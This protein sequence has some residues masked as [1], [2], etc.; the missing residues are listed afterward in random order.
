MLKY[1]SD[2]EFFK[3][4]YPATL[5]PQGKEIVR[6]WLYYT[7]LRG[8]LETGKA[9]FKDTW[10]HQHIL[11]EKGRKMSKSEGNII[12]PQEILKEDGAEVLRF[13]AATEGDLSKGD[14]TCSKEKIKAERKS[15]NKLLNVSRFVMMFEK[16]KEKPTLTSLDNLFINYIEGLTDKCDK[17]Y[18]VYDFNHPAQ[19]LRKFLWDTFAS[20]YIELIK[21]RVYNE[22]KQFTEKESASA[23][24]TLHFLLERFLLIIYPII[25]QITSTIAKE[26]GIDLLKSEWPKVKKT[27]FKIDR[28]IIEKIIKFNSKVWKIKKEKGIT[29]RNSIEGIKIPKELMSFEKDLKACHSI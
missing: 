23:K 14:F 17:S 10:I 20:S 22:K 7:I 24:Y 2:D 6:T 15:L 3:K 9:C 27:E 1:K 29:L 21:N 19:D 28:Q 8:F 5:R 18:E 26:K 13:W 4:A 16:P 25:P 11:D 12:D